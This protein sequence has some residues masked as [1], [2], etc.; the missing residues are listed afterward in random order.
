MKVLLTGAAGQLGQAL[1]ASAPSLAIQAMTSSPA[2]PS[3]SLEQSTRSMKNSD[4]VFWIGI[5]Q[6]GQ[7][8]D[9][10]LDHC[11]A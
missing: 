9:A 5:S 3:D 10:D 4:I 1:T 2:D 6:S 7:A 11:S 8:I